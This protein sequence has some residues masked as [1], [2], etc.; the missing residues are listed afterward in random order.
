MSLNAQS[1]YTRSLLSTGTNEQI[2]YSGLNYNSD[3][4]RWCWKE[5]V[6][7]Y[8]DCDVDPETDEWIYYDRYICYIE[9][10]IFMAENIEADYHINVSKMSWGD[11]RIREK[12][13][14]Y[15]ILESQEED[16]A[17]TFEVVAKLKDGATIT[18]NAIIANNSID[19]EASVSVPQDIE[20]AVDPVDSI[21]IQQN[22]ITGE[23]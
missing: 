15:F 14:Y 19:T 13:Q 22:I 6:F 5:N 7:T 8:Q 12:N 4:I 2:S 18:N 20:G 23:E 16:F 1:E 11:W 17:F 10:P 21:N 3:E 9:L